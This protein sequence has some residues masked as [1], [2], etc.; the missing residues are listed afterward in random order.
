MSRSLCTYVYV[1][2]FNLY[3]RAV[4]N[5]PHKWLN[6]MRLCRQTLNPEDKIER[7]RYFTADVSGRR[8]KDAPHRQQVYLRALITLPGVSIHK[9][10][11]LSSTKWA[12]IA[13]PPP[14]FVRPNPVTVSVVKTEEKGFDVNLASHLLNDA[15]NHRFDVGVVLSNDTDLVEPLRMVKEE[16]AKPVGIICPCSKAARSLKKVASFVRHISPSRLAAS[17]FANPIPGTTI[18]K[19]RSW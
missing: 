2:G 3:Y 11:F 18:T 4:C 7:L 9:G 14:S 17:Q 1:D 12:E 13:H 16:L 5:T 19:P 15:F 10:N 6:L 8:D